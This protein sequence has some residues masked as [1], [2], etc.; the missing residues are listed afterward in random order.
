MN[1]GNFDFPITGQDEL[2]TERVNMMP[3]LKEFR[4]DEK[5]VSQLKRIYD[6][7]NMICLESINES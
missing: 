2:F 4:K 6:W 1:V 5:S 3:W 7:I